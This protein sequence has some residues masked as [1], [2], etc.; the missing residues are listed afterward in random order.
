[1]QEPAINSIT[2]LLDEAISA[3]IFPGVVVQW[4]HGARHLQIARGHLRYEN[5]LPVEPTTIYDLASLSKLWTLAAWLLVARDHKISASQTVGEFLPAF[6]SSEKSTVQIAHLLDHSSGIE[7]AIQSFVPLDENDETNARNALKGRCGEDWIQQLAE[8]PLLSAPGSEVLYSCSNYFLLARV[9]AKIIGGNL[10]Q[11][12]VRRLMEPLYNADESVRTTFAPGKYLPGEI[13]PTETQS[14]G[15]TFCGK[16]HDEA[17]RFYTA[18]DEDFCGNAGVFADTEGVMR[19]ARLWLNDGAHENRQI[20]YPQDIA[21]C[22]EDL[23]LENAET[24]AR[25]GWCW[26][27]DSPLYMTEN[28][29]RGSIG[30]LG[31]TGPSL[32]LHRETQ[33]VCVVLNN[34]VHPT[35]DG[36]N[37][38]PLLR[39]ISTEFLNF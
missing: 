35:R 28:A 24:G 38:F 18:T 19:F 11:F 15:E 2:A 25:R 3:R 26:Q 12:I 23:R 5:A 8:A 9:L 13:A 32:W 10:E 37:R 29:P 30:H 7:C 1:M 34:R 39:Q 14:N 33:R 6:Q 17:A 16:I 4:Q 22:F 20:F 36:P 27:I 21:A 31:F